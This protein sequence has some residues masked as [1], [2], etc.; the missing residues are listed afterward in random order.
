MDS[1]LLFSLVGAAIVTVCALLSVKLL[2]DEQPAPETTPR[3]EEPP[4]DAPVDLVAIANR[5]EP[6]MEKLAHP[7]DALEN[8]DFRTAVAALS[9]D[10][11]S[12]EQVRNYALGANW[13][14]ACAGFEALARRSDAAEVVDKA[15]KAVP[16]A[17]AWPL[18]F[19]I[20]FVDAASGEGVAARV[21]CNAQYWWANNTVVVDSVAA[22][23]KKVSDSG[24]AIA[25]GEEY[26]DLGSEEKESL[27]SFVK[28]LPDPPQ[29]ELQASL[30]QYERQA[31]DWKFLGSVGVILDS[32]STGDPVFETERTRQHKSDILAELETTPGRSVL[33]VGMSGVGKSAFAGALAR[34][35]IQRGWTVLK[36]SA[37]ALIA[38]QSYIGQIEGQVRRLASN[39]TVGK[40]V[41]VYVENLS[42]LRQFGRYKGKDSSVLDQLWPDIAAR[43]VLLIGETTPTGLQA[44]LKDHPS[45]S[46]VMR[47]INIEAA[48]EDE[49]AEIATKLLRHLVGDLD[50]NRT[51]EIVTESLQ[52]AQQYLAHK[53][54]PGSVL[55]LLRLA[56]LRAER[57]EAVDGLRREHVLGALSQ[58]SGLPRDVL[59]E[60]QQLDIAGVARFFKSRVVGQDEA[61]D[62]LVERIAMLKA[63]LTDPGRPIGVFLFAGPTG[64]GKTEIAKTLADVLF[65]SAEQMIRLDMSEFQDAASTSRL[66]GQTD[67]DSAGGSLVDQIREDPFSVLLLDEFEKAHPKIWDMFLQVFDDG[68]L[69]DS[70]GQLAD[71]RHAIVI[72]TSNL[73]A[74]I[75]SE[76]GIGF[77]STSG[78]FSSKDVLRV[79]NRTFRR[80]FIN[81]LDRVVVFKP[82]SREVMRVI[83]QKELE[84]ALGRRGFRSKQWAVEWEDSAIEFLL[85]EGFTPDLGARPLRR[86]IERHLLA[87]LSIT[88]V[89]NE[90]PVGEQFLFVR[91]NGE[92]LTVEF[93]DPD[94]NPEP[95]DAGG[96]RVAGST[97]ELSLAALMLSPD[98]FDGA[99][100]FLAGEM[101]EVAARM[102]TDDWIDR[103]SRS[104]EQ[105][106][107]EGFWDRGDRHR[108]LDR[109]ELTDRLDSAAAAL[110]RLVARLEQHPGSSK[111]VA[112]VAGRLY[113]LKEGLEDFDLERPTQA[114]LGVRLVTADTE[115]PGADEFLQELVRMYRRW[116]RDRGMRL[117]EIDAGASRYDA[118][119]MVSGFGSYGILKP[120]SG[121][122]VFEAPLGATKF[123]RIRARVEVAGVPVDIPGRPPDRTVE[124]TK[125]LDD[126]AGKVEVVRRYRRDPS[127]LVRDSVRHWRSGRLDTVLAGSF[128]ILG[129]ASSGGA[130]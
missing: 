120:E 100:E 43:R 103:K 82:L 119:F 6:V 75:A 48:R 126:L 114:Y 65:G 90:V 111:L 7:S 3:P 22:Y 124:A 51:T 8:D 125:R 5:L 11:Y 83:L 59:D 73:G 67:G 122:H 13:I 94:A 96:S 25:F 39:A 54:L 62:C 66:I 60:Q 57:D 1:L 2:K 130:D 58:V 20:K 74:T 16:G 69:T 78:G 85:S 79:V 68:R 9:S 53:S 86:A 31:V 44:L 92:R 107:G 118:L 102:R 45:L 123:D 109:I 34:E 91:S 88:M 113:V 10:R 117:K 98:A 33:L 4:S 72:L 38:D 95:G 28:A 21:L 15:V 35:F 129:E 70:N 63:G 26:A 101:S 47:V 116:C 61:V 115:K 29:A 40:K 80:E 64:T 99:A 32:D 52:L 104:I 56:T 30:E 121:L 71:F 41:A 50:E 24:E 14:L 55:S 76:A 17:Y 81:R 110:D 106:G 18:Y 89:Q 27:A 23:L 37:A 112:S 93:I 36:T 108:I 46:T 77:T 84:K 97:G 49:T 19:L 12:V 128:D 127:P 42:E 87:P 105:I